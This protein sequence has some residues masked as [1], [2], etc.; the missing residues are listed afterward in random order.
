MLDDNVD[1]EEWAKVL[2]TRGLVEKVRE[3]NLEDAGD[4]GGV[5]LG[6]TAQSHENGHADNTVVEAAN[7]DSLPAGSEN[8]VLT[9]KEVDDA[10]YQA[11]LC[12]I[13]QYKTTNSTQN[14]FGL[15][16]P[17]SQ[18]FV[19]ST[20]VQPYLPIF[21]PEQKEQLQIKKTSWPDQTS[22]G[23]YAEIR[24][25]RSKIVHD[26][27]DLCFEHHRS[28]AGMDDFPH[29]KGSGDGAAMPWPDR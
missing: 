13:H 6:A 25:L 16:F 20:L 27:S 29:L 8:K 7:P 2:N 10:F 22:G 14:N 4:D 3:M 24:R 1:I 17:L 9:Q 21:S 15:V 26:G 11:F 5:T 18:S 23:L 19:M 28:A 12:G